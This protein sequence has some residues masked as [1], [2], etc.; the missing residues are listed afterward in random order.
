MELTLGQVKKIP[1]QRVSI[2]APS[3]LQSALAPFGSSPETEETMKGQTTATA[4]T[5]TATESP[6]PVPTTNVRTSCTFVLKNVNPN[7]QHKYNQMSQASNQNYI[8]MEIDV[9]NPSSRLQQQQLHHQRVHSKQQQKFASLD[10]PRHYDNSQCQVPGCQIAATATT[11]T[12]TNATK[13]STNPEG[14]LPRQL[15][16]SSQDGR[17]QLKQQNPNPIDIARSQQQM[18]SQNSQIQN[19]SEGSSNDNNK[20]A[21]SHH[22]S[23]S[24]YAVRIPT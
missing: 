3:Q 20:Q 16:A 19:L 12:T 6:A 11:T 10:D 4:A 7:D 1:H 9:A 15:Q 8:S 13:S 2:G 22:Q 23:S 18:Q 24:N 17:N 14:Q 21:T 5:A